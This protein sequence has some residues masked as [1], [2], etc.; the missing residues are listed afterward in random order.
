MEILPFIPDHIYNR[1]RD[2]HGRYGGNWQSGISTSATQP[3]IFIFTGKAGA[4]HG[5]ADRWENHNV[6]SY[7]GEGQS[8]D[9]EFTRGNLALR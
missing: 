1:R 2:I 3:Y 6:F 7:T 4:Q 9:M 5:Y 8:G